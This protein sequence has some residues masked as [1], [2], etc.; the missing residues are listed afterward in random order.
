MSDDYRQLMLDAVRELRTLRARVAELERTSAPRQGA[1][2]VGLGCRL[3]MGIEDPAALWQFLRQGQH[4]IGPAPTD[5][6]LPEEAGE[7]L[8]PG[9][10]LGDPY[11]FDAQFFKIAP[12]EARLVDPQQRL[13]LEVAHATLEH[14]GIAPNSLRGSDTGVFVGISTDDWAMHLTRHLP[15]AEV[16]GVSGTGTNTCA[17]AG[18]L[19]FAFGLQGPSL[20]VNT[21]CSSSLVALH[22]ALQSL[23]AGECELAL[24]L[25]VNMMLTPSTTLAFARAGMLARDG[26]CKTFDRGADGYGRGEGAVGLLLASPAAAARRGLR[27]HAELLGSALNQDGAT[28]GLTVPS[29]PAQ[30][31]VLRQALRDA[32]CAATDLQ[33][34]EAHG[35]GTQ[36]GD[37]IEVEALAA[38]HGVGRSRETP[39]YL[40]SVKGNFGHLE[41]AA[42]LL[43]VL[44][45][46][47]QIEHRTLVPHL[48]PA[49]NPHVPWQTL[50]FQIPDR[51][52]P[53]PAAAR[54][55]A[56]VSSFSF[57]GTNAHV[58]LAAAPAAAA[59]PSVHDEP[60]PPPLLPLSARTPSALRSLC[61]RWAEHL[62]QHPDTD[63]RDLI[64]TAAL[65]RSPQRVRAAVLADTLTQ[66][67][68]RLQAAADGEAC[69]GVVHGTVPPGD[70]P[71]DVVAP[72]ADFATLAAAWTKGVPIAWAERLPRQRRLLA[73]PTYPFQRRPFRVA[74]R[75]LASVS[76]PA[77]AVASDATVVAPIRGR[78][79]AA[80]ADA[81]ALL[82]TQHVQTVCA[83]LLRLNEDEIG[84]DEPLAEFGFDS[85]R[86]AELATRLERE[87]GVELP[88]VE[89]RDGATAADVGAAIARRLTATLPDNAEA[90]LAAIEAMS[91][92]E[93]ARRLREA[94]GDG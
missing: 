66:L 75:P 85:M 32:G 15:L 90:L 27:T 51:Q 30:Q 3:P 41:A 47:L 18:R 20:A 70:P 29:G 31:R 5:R 93:A 78:A 34:V 54:V 28:A 45:T 87:L 65:G 68:Q 72:T 71:T 63:L 13:V 40:G 83:D 1:A 24:V 4:A 42:G 74:L 79:L 6:W 94:R 67:A 22:L 52:L 84:S 86:A 43:A 38:V 62:R 2:I 80:P 11:G 57:T 25:G 10:F 59:A 23:R 53:W 61:A 19:S 44:K 55:L 36:L 89:L 60:L 58:I 33:Y 91:P 82:L 69:P 56:G 77:T 14:A 16:E 35:T 17:A 76:N 64:A 92:E 81:R 49:G 12:R 21:A 9:A 7:A 26:H 8:P 37:P 39:L 46:V 50:P 73:L 88:L 48:H